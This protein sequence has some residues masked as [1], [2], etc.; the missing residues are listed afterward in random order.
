MNVTKINMAKGSNHS[1][2]NKGDL[3]V[4]YCI[5]SD[6]VIDWTYTIHDHMMKAKRLTNF[7]FP[8]VLQKA[9]VDYGE[10]CKTLGKLNK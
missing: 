10:V 7:K 1:T 6:V 5:K 4:M 3:V 2:L 8:Y 9:E